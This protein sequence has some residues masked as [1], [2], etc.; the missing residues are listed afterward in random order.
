MVEYYQ[1]YTILHIMYQ[2]CCGY[3]K[4]SDFKKPLAKSTPYTNLVVKPKEETTKSG[5]I[6]D[7]DRSK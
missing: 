2:N 6:S 1:Y 4:Y 3:K 7:Y 5:A